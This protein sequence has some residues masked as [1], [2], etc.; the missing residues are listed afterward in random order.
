[1]NYEQ[2]SLK[3]YNELK[4]ELQLYFNEFRDNLI[5]KGMTFQEYLRINDKIKNKKEILNNLLKKIKQ[6]LKIT[7]LTNWLI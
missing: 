3:L 6:R 1:M 4:N 2:K 5:K 7:D